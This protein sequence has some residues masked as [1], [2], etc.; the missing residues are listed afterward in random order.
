MNVTGKLTATECPH[1][2][3]KLTSD[4]GYGYHVHCPDCEISAMAPGLAGKAIAAFD[5]EVRKQ[6][7]AEQRAR[8]KAGGS[9]S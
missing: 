8:D 9:V 2:N 7:A 6:R 3:F 4:P 5:R 1:T